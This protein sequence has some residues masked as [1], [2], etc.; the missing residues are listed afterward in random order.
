MKDSL[1]LLIWKWK[2]Q[3]KYRVNE[4]KITKA[5]SVYKKEPGLKP[6]PSSRTASA[7]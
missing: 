3:E 7:T 6:E 4:V 2:S 5:M 1:F